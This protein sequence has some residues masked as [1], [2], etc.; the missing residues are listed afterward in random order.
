MVSKIRLKFENY[1]FGGM[2]IFGLFLIIA[3]I[4]YQNLISGIIGTLIF[5]MNH[6]VLEVKKNEK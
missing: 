2:E 6:L 3:G 4:K 1:T 5:F